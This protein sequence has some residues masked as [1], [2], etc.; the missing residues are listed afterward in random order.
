M[1]LDIQEFKG[2][3]TNIDDTTRSLSFCSDCNKVLFKGSYVEIQNNHNLYKEHKIYKL[4]RCPFPIYDTYK[5][6]IDIDI[7]LVLNNGD[8]IVVYRGKAYKIA[9]NIID[10][11]AHPYKGLVLVCIKN[12]YNITSNIVIYNYFDGEKNIPKWYVLEDRLGKDYGESNYG[13]NEKR[14]SL[15][16]GTTYFNNGLFIRLPHDLNHGA[17]YFIEIDNYE[18]KKL[19]V[20]KTIKIPIY[21]VTGKKTGEKTI[22]I[23]TLEYIYLDTPISNNSK[24]HIDRIDGS[25]KS[26]YYS[27][28]YKNEFPYH[29][30]F[31]TNNKENVTY[32][33]FVTG[34]LPI[35]PNRIFKEDL[36]HNGI[37]TVDNVWHGIIDVRG[38]KNYQEISLPYSN[39]FVNITQAPEH[40]E[41]FEYLKK[42][43]K[44]HP[45]MPVKSE[46][47]YWSD[48]AIPQL[49]TRRVSKKN[50]LIYDYRP[51]HRPFVLIK[52]YTL[53]DNTEYIVDVKHFSIT[54]KKLYADMTAVMHE[55]GKSL[56]IDVQ[57]RD[58]FPIDIIKINYYIAMYPYLAT[59][60][61][62]YNNRA[63]RGLFGKAQLLDSI[64]LYKD[65]TKYGN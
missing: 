20:N 53:I 12:I 15:A 59:K 36:L 17:V 50:D 29:S 38:R 48:L 34:D 7:K 16:A 31:Y 35:D 54:T 39:Y 52:T 60:K 18:I 13:I 3:F 9:N 45:K 57:I 41:F 33:D 49:Y 61:Y 43:V 19:E 4:D 55:I 5:E 47:Y 37:F 30:I 63:T 26:P 1:R 40:K 56:Y 14:T 23:D 25:T 64:E 6:N 58:D 65:R 32:E 8:L 62:D 11:N 46:D 44:Y 21:D 28:F 2:L 24:I 42:R 27:I 10:Y 51:F 22:V